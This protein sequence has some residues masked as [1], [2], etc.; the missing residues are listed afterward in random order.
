MRHYINL[1]VLYSLLTEYT[2]VGPFELNWE[3]QQYKCRLAQIVTFGLLAALQAV[4]LFWLFMIFRIA[5]RFVINWGKEIADERSDYDDTG[6]EAPAEEEESTA[7]KQATLSP[8]VN[9]R[10][11]GT[12]NG[13]ETPQVMLNGGPVPR[14]PSPAGTTATP[15][16]IKSRLRKQKGRK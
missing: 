4:N 3:L 12:P 9:G 15:D 6:D 11:N 1:V 5:Y 16:T 14:T 7:V 10:A 13:K 8:K 2:T